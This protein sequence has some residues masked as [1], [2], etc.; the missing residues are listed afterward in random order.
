MADGPP[1]Q[2]LTATIHLS[3]IIYNTNLLHVLSL[4]FQQK[5]LM[6][7]PKTSV[8][9]YQHLLLNISDNESFL[10]NV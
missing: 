3:K 7:C 10:K 1:E 8:N 5:G 9:N 6:D 4:R 2:N